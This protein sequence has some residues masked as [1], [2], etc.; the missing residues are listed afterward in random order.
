MLKLLRPLL[1]DQRGVSSVEY[2]VLAVG[3]GL[4]VMTGASYLAGNINQA[5]TDIAERVVAAI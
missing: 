4:I 5:F 1:R 2:A 3:L